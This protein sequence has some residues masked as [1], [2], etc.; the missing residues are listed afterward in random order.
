MA[1]EVVD[2]LDEILREQNFL[3]EGVYDAVI[4]SWT[5]IRTTKSRGHAYIQVKVKVNKKHSVFIFLPG[6]Y[7]TLKF[8]HMLLLKVKGM[9]VKIAV[10]HRMF[11]EQMYMEGGF[12]F[13]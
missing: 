1:E 3:E 10:K 2:V 12:K 4:E 6:G 8:L 13:D 9:K 5:E 11:N 7:H